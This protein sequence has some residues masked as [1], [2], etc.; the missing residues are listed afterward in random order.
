[1]DQKL[2][3]L[4]R[5]LQPASLLHLGEHLHAMNDAKRELIAQWGRG[6]FSGFEPG[7]KKKESTLS[8][9]LFI[10]VTSYEKSIVLEPLHMESLEMIKRVLGQE[11]PDVARAI[12]NLAFLYYSQG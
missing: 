8:S 10:S 9:T 1:M 3:L 6:D 7:K 2:R 4:S 11:R 12:N 5:S